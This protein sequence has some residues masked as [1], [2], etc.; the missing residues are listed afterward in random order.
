[1]SSQSKSKFG[2]NCNIFARC[3]I[4][5]FFLFLQTTTTTTNTTTICI[6]QHQ[7]ITEKLAVLWLEWLPIIH[8]FIYLLFSSIH[9]QVGIL[10][11][12]PCLWMW[13]PWSLF[14]LLSPCQA[15]SIIESIVDENNIQQWKTVLQK[16][17]QKKIQDTH[18][19][20]SQSFCS[21]KAKM[22]DY[23]FLYT[24]HSTV[25]IMHHEH[26]DRNSHFKG[27]MCN[28]YRDLMA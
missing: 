6:C 27:L 17:L 7:M 9:S 10:F 24:L 28:A 5:F 19:E 20:L 2:C 23:S 18:T 22:D 1:M 11:Y 4:S 25:P 13:L 3:V 8:S 26:T 12:C 14:C 16:Q 15:L 21:L